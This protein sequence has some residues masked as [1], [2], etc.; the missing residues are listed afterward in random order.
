MIFKQVSVLA[1][2]LAVL[3]TLAAPAGAQGSSME[4]I[5]TQQR[6]QESNRRLIAQRDRDLCAQIAATPL[7]KHFKLG[8]PADYSQPLYSVDVVSA[9]QE[10]PSLT[11]GLFGG[12]SSSV[13]SLKD[14]QGRLVQL[15]PVSISVIPPES[16]GRYEVEFRLPSGRRTKLFRNDRAHTQ[17]NAMWFTREELD[18]IA[19]QRLAVMANSQAL[20]PIIERLEALS[21]SQ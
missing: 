15:E 14:Q 4:R 21:Q 12:I 13:F 6:I 7:I 17:K 5:V 8:E 19:S 9:Y 1:A 2:L 20:D 16:D 18:G 3:L 10:N 11:L